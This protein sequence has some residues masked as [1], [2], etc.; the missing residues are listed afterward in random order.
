[1]TARDR[2]SEL[3]KRI[4]NIKEAQKHEK[5]AEALEDK[6]KA[7]ESFRSTLQAGVVSAGVLVKNQCLEPATLPDPTKLSDALDKLFE[8]F[9]KDPGS[10]TKGRN[11]TT[12]AGQ[13]ETTTKAIRDTILTAWKKEI[14]KA[15]KTND[16]LLTQIAELPGQRAS[17]EQLRKA[18]TLLAEASKKPPADEEEWKEYQE[19]L[20]VVETK[21][22]QLSADHFPRA[23]LDFCI[24]AQSGGARL[25]LLTDDVRAWLTERGMLQDLRYR[26]K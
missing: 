23:V 21:V 17:V 9:L 24:A 20:Q 5:H 26:F 13:I 22:G 25:P 7:L 18:D 11:F 4:S 1:M 8:S 19:L 3:R 12:L 10:I 15:S 6:R 16:S 14:G 2:A